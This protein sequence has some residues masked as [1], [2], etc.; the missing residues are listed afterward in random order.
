MNRCERS[1]LVLLVTLASLSLVLGSAACTVKDPLYCD[2]STPCAAGSRCAPDA[3]TCEATADGGGGLSDT[4]VHLGDAADFGTGADV[5]VDTSVDGVADALSLDAIPVDGGADSAMPVGSLCQT[6]ADCASGYCIDDVC[7]ESACTDTCRSCARSPA[8]LGQCLLVGAGA[9]PRGDCSGT[10]PACKGQC[11]GQGQCSFPANELTCAASTCV[12]GDASAFT[13]DGLGACAE[14]TTSCG[15]FVCDGDSCKTTCI[16]ANDCSGTFGCVGGNCVA[17]L[18]DGAVCGVNAQACKSK[19]CV[20]G[21]CC[22]SSSCSTCNACNMPGSEG[23]CSP[24]ING[25]A[26]ATTNCNGGIKSVFGCIQGSCQATNTSCG[27]YDCNN[28]ATECRTSCSLDE[29][30]ADDAYCAATTCQ[31]KKSAGSLCYAAKECGT[32]FCVASSP[33]APS[34]C[35]DKACGAGPCESCA[36]IGKVGTCSFLTA[37]EACP[38][39]GADPNLDDKCD[40]INGEEILVHRQCNGLSAQCADVATLCDPYYCDAT[41]TL[42]QSTCSVDTDCNSGFCDQMDTMQVKNSCVAKSALCNVDASAVGGGDG[43]EGAPFQL[44]QS[45]LDLPSVHYVV[46]AAGGYSENLKA[47]HDVEI[48]ARGM[49]EVIAPTYSAVEVIGPDRVGLDGLRLSASHGSGVF[50]PANSVVEGRNLDVQYCPTAF[51]TFGTMSLDT[52]KIDS[53]TTGVRGIFATLSMTEVDITNASG[54][55]IGMVGGTFTGNR[56]AISQ[57]GQALTAASTTVNI[58][59]L[60]VF[61]NQDGLLLVQSSGGLISNLVTYDNTGDTVRISDC[62]SSTVDI[63]YSTI[64]GDR[65]QTA[66]LFCCEGETALNSKP[67]ISNTIVWD[68][69]NADTVVGPCQFAY[70]DVRTL[71]GTVV[72]GAGNLQ[73]DPLFV[74]MAGGDFRLSGTSPCVNKGSAGY[75]G[76]ITPRS[77]YWG[78]ERVESGLLDI[79]ADEVS[80]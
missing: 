13:C 19:Q 59:R 35:C 15:G 14:A 29:H 65:D 54:V 78:G 24:T 52:V 67:V 4:V 25:A 21:V 30:C 34:Y 37:G 26:C 17:E 62:S 32:G 42:C 31:K 63:A 73:A 28:S 77:D 3:R 20:D 1:H 51:Q 7:C 22:A 66:D 61:D 44:I 8:E 12:A 45:C 2:E 69:K 10:D 79:G 9:D 55:G 50:A 49:V 56:I 38:N 16:T 11:D 60:G 48:V 18:A 23:V 76:T 64:F 43:S 80:P 74:N 6:T 72:S 5:S 39:P 47:G 68:E 70:S 36:V 57:S 46:V 33:G 40:R 58:D 75:G 71:S 41:T 27:N 53:V